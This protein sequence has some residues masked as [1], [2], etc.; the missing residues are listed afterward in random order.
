MEPMEFVRRTRSEEVG[1]EFDRRVERQAGRARGALKSG[2]LDG[3][4]SLGLELEGYAVDG[5]GRIAAVP[6]SAF[7][8]FCERELGRH[9]AELNT[10]PTAF[11]PAGL[12]AQAGTLAERL[13]ALRR[14]LAGADLGFVT[15]GMWTIE[16]PEGALAYL[17]DRH[18]VDGRLVSPNMSPAGR[19]YALD[20]DIVSA[21]PVELDVPGCSRRFP[22]ILVESLT[23]SMQIHLQVPTAA[24]PRYYDAALRTAGPVLA[25][26]TNSPFLPVVLYDDPDPR[27]VLGGPAELRVPVFEAMN[28]REPGKVRFPRDL[29][30]PTDVLDRLLADRRCVPCLSEW[31]E[32]DDE[33]DFVAEHW[34]LLHKQGTY[35]RWVRPILGPDG[36]RLEYRPLPA[37]P[38]VA[39]T[40]GFQAL[41]AGLLHGIVTTDHPLLD[42]PWVD[43]RESFYAAA[44][45]GIDADLAWIS[46]EGERTSDFDRLYADLFA[47][48]RE[49]LRDRG[50]APDRIDGLLAPVEGRWRERATPALWKRDRVR[51]R[52]A[53][54]VDLAS[55]VEGAQRAYVRRA[56][57]GTP[58]VSW[59]E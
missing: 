54:G 56:A 44:D 15:D 2:R 48:A 59:L 41:V 23:T 47:L 50:F 29:D 6:E 24:F 36:L 1:A 30:S 43:A 55:A 27:T 12:D 22:T 46:R 7:G 33:G 34:E 28:V 17:T 25:L 26:A 8:P 5:R 31:F 18:E 49:G 42:L 35:W 53:D 13:G 3:D 16:P 4:F 37:Q 10:P 9:N 38:T 51:E 52:L 45:R 32:E 39:D 14:A 57:S 21:G 19:Y 40:I 11:D 20:A 58:F